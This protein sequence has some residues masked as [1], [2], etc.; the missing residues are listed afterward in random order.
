MDVQTVRAHLE[1]MRGES[2]DARQWCLYQRH[3]A[4]AQGCRVARH[5]L[6]GHGYVGRW[7]GMAA[8]GANPFGLLRLFALLAHHPQPPEDGAVIRDQ[9]VQQASCQRGDHRIAARILPEPA[10]HVRI[11]PP[12]TKRIGVHLHGQRRNL[13][14]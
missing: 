4:P 6:R 1:V 11:Q 12:R 10:Q 3:R 5:D 2:G 7:G 8:L 14:P 13:A 9:Q